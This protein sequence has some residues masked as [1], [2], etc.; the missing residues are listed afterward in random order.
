MT[1]DVVITLRPGQGT[2]GSYISWKP[3]DTE[4]ACDRTTR[5]NDHSAVRWLCTESVSTVTVIDVMTMSAVPSDST[6]IASF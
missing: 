6:A 3:G 2:T 5:R 4:C 1:G